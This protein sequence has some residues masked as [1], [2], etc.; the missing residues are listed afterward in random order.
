MLDASSGVSTL[1]LAA[2]NQQLVIAGAWRETPRHQETC[3][4]KGLPLPLP[5]RSPLNQ[6]R[7]QEEN[8]ERPP[9]PK[10]EKFARGREQ[11]TP[12]PA[13]KIDSTN[14]FKF[15]L[16]FSKYLLNFL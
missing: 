9:P 14:K 6:G 1:P 13:M 2:T 10:P 8:G 16:R 7:R 5:L 3:G 15:S 12:Q 4:L 11:L